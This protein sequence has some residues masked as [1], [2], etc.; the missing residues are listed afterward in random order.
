[1]AFARI[2]VFPDGTQEQYEHLASLMGEGVAHQP[3]RRLI[4]A[5]PS[6]GGWAIIQ[7]W[8][9]KEPLERFIADH[10]SPAMARAGDLGYPQPP[11]IIDVELVDLHT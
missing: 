8:N 9:S 6:E 2:A 5:G 11:R 1:M 7:V 10:L 3:E 4:A